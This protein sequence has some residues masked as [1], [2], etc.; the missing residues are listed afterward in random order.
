MG[1]NEGAA[2]S[3]SPAFIR[4]VSHRQWGTSETRQLEF[5]SSRLLDRE[6]RRI[7]ATRYARTCVWTCIRRVSV[8][9]WATELWYTCFVSAVRASAYISIHIH[10]HI[11]NGWSTRIHLEKSEQPMSGSTEDSEQLPVT[12]CFCSS[13]GRRATGASPLRR[14]AAVF[15]SSLAFKY[16]RS[17]LAVYRTYGYVCFRQPTMVSRRSY[18]KMRWTRNIDRSFFFLNSKNE[19]I[20]NCFGE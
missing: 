18:S 5:V 3:S 11:R 12:C 15:D 1:M 2:S 16:Y 7:A 4:N 8:W 13:A 9:Q 19:T 17:V 10:I 14:P 6:G 20:A